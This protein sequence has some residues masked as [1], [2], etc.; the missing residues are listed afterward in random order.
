[1]IIDAIT[2]AACDTT[3][4]VIKQTQG[5]V[6]ETLDQVFGFL[7][8]PKTLGRVFKKLGYI[9]RFLSM[10]KDRAFCE[11]LFSQKLSS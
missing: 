10:I 8:K 6:F 9:H 3:R 2:V 4:L 11:T 5:Q 1:M 7:L